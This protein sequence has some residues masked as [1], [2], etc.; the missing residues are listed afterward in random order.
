MFIAIEND[1]ESPRMKNFLKRW[2][3]PDT[4]LIIRKKYDCPYGE[5]VVTVAP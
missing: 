2:F 4:K 1:M 3:G 5:L